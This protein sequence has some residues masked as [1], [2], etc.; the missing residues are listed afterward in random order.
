MCCY[1]PNNASDHA[2]DSAAS[3]P[4]RRHLD[5]SPPSIPSALDTLEAISP[6]GRESMQPWDQLRKS[7]QQSGD[8]PMAGMAGMAAQ[9]PL[10]VS[11]RARQGSFEN[12]GKLPNRSNANGLSEETNIYT[13]TRMLQ[14][15]TGR[16]RRCSRS[17]GTVGPGQDCLT[18]LSSSLHWR[19]VDTVHSAVDPHHRREH[20]RVR[21]GLTIYR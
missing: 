12:F 20:R 5:T 1:T 9:L 14:D 10:P 15:Q 7:E 21:H 6:Q 11:E 19:C 17:C 8:S 4:K 3:P 18:C 16:L 13:E 2:A